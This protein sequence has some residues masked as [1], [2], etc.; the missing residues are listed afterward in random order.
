MSQLDLFQD[1]LPLAC[2]VHTACQE[3]VNWGVVGKWLSIIAQRKGKIIYY[4]LSYFKSK[5]Q[6]ETVV[7]SMEEATPYPDEKA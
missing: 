7:L 4:A 6:I 3:N 5:P 1:A 2:L